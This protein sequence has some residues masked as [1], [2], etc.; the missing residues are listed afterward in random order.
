MCQMCYGKGDKMQLIVLDEHT[1][2]CVQCYEE[3]SQVYFIDLDAE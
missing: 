3:L 2:V 1:A